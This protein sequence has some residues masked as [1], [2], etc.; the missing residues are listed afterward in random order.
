MTAACTATRKN[1]VAVIRK[2][3]STVI[4]YGCRGDRLEA[5]GRKPTRFLNAFANEVA[6]PGSIRAK[7]FRTSVVPKWKEASRADQRDRPHMFE[8][9]GRAGGCRFARIHFRVACQK[10]GGP[11]RYLDRCLH[12][13]GGQ[14]VR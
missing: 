10:C 2:P 5:T 12:R 9:E 4:Y 8:R 6:G 3:T 1:R 11:A 7:R 14:G 13:E